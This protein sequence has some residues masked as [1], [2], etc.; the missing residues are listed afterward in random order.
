MTKIVW[1][2]GLEMRV[3]P[4]LGTR[5]LL[6]AA[7]QRNFCVL[8]DSMCSKP[9]KINSCWWL[10]QC[11]SSAMSVG[12]KGGLMGK[13]MAFTRE[14]HSLFLPLATRQVI[15]HFFNF[16]V[17]HFVKKRRKNVTPFRAVLWIHPG[18][19]KHPFV[20][21][22]TACA[23]VPESWP[24]CCW[25][26]WE[27]SLG[28]SSFPAGEW[29]DPSQGAAGTTAP[30][31]STI[32]D[33]QAQ[34]SSRPWYIHCFSTVISHAK[35]SLNPSRSCSSSLV[36]QYLILQLVLRNLGLILVKLFCMFD[37]LRP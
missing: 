4:S 37:L 33:Q 26:W 11:N 17:C 27:G 19:A 7:A 24:G 3:R 22:R 9:S 20:C 36:Q 32:A 10:I 13:G 6:S 2:D 34:I 23:R 29:R 28:Q 14:V 31:P 12:C 35:A 21:V 1:E 15:R 5:K 30:T 16:C 18:S 25:W 8:V